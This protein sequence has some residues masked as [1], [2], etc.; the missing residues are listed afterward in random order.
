MTDRVC[1]NVGHSLLLVSISP[2]NSVQH[3]LLT[4]V[5]YSLL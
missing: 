5:C 1:P 4:A 3:L 2:A